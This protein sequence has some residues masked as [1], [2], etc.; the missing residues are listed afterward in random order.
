MSFGKTSLSDY[1]NLMNGYRSIKDNTPKSIKR[2]S[3]DEER[4]YAIDMATQLH[5]MTHSDPTPVVDLLEKAVITSGEPEY[6][7]QATDALESVV[8]QSFSFLPTEVTDDFFTLEV[9]E[10]G[11]K[12]WSW[13]NK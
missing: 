2:L 4:Q 12:L 1:E 3:S 6:R 8:F 11:A 5:S 13:F 7:Y 9:I 10:Q